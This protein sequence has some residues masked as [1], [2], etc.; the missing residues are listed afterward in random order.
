MTTSVADKGVIGSGRH[1]TAKLDA[2]IHL[3][4]ILE[5]IST[6]SVGVMQARDFGRRIRKTNFRFVI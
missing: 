3:N 5:S 4:L 6:F 2:S 1:N